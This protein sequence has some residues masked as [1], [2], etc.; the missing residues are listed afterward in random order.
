[1]ATEPE[2]PD[3]HAPP[4][5]ET[6]KLLAAVAVTNERV[7]ARLETLVRA[8]DQL[9]AEVREVG[10]TV[11]PLAEGSRA[12]AAAGQRAF[13]LLQK[14]QITQA[15]A[16]AIV[17]VAAAMGLPLFVGGMLLATRDPGAVLAF[18]AALFGLAQ[19]G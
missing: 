10:G 15:L 2:A 3:P 4:L 11:E 1:M 5:S 19:G 6:Y 7:C 13:T 12:R 18:V 8:I 9:T 16:I 17:V 14:L